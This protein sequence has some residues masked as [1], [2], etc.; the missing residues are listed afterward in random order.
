MDR[1]QFLKRLGDEGNIQTVAILRQYLESCII[2]VHE[3][4]ENSEEDIHIL[5]G[6]VKAYRKLHKLLIP[7]K[8]SEDVKKT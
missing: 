3:R 5:R 6:E 1:N 7:R 8:E 2:E 4:M